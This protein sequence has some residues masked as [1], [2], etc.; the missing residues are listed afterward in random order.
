MSRQ[1]KITK[2]L[3]NKHLQEIKKII[4]KT[5]SIKDIARLFNI[6]PG[7]LREY[8]KKHP[9]FEKIIQDTLYIHNTEVDKRFSEEE[10]NAIQLQA[11]ATGKLKKI[12]EFLN[13]HPATLKQY[14]KKS[15]KLDVAIKEG[16]KK[17]PTELSNY[18]LEKLK[19]ISKTGD[20]I[21]PP[22]KY[23]TYAAYLTSS[24]SKNF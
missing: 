15:K 4:L 11:Q 10:L 22:I 5:G 23:P 17:Y 6:S 21:N 13:I 9:K 7:T 20:V 1:P 24:A 14:R 18:H 12:A 19:E 2:Y 16:L 8:R 3:V